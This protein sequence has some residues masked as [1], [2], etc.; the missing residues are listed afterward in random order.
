MERPNQIEYLKIKEIAK[1]LKWKYIHLKDSR[2]Y[3]HLKD[4]GAQNKIMRI[5]ENL[6]RKYLKFR[7]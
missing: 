6:E 1:N 7:S 5:S 2:V 4:F 3:L